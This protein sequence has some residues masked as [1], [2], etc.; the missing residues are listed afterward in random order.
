ML[1]FDN[2]PLPKINSGTSD[3]TLNDDLLLIDSGNHARIIPK[4]TIVKLR[5][6]RNLGYVILP[7][8]FNFQRIYR[9]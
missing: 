5:Q 3:F 8:S 4:D 1:S 7:S 6:T 9:Y 2:L